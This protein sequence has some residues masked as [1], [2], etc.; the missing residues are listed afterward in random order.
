MSVSLLT[1][2]AAA[3]DSHAAAFAAVRGLDRESA[4]AALSLAANAGDPDAMFALGLLGLRGQVLWEFLGD[5]AAISS[6][7]QAEIWSSVRW[8]RAAADQG[9]APSMARLA[10]LRAL[11]DSERLTWLH[12]AA[13]AGAWRAASRYG[14]WLS[15]AGRK[16]EARRW[17]L[18]DVEAGSANAAEC[19]A[20]FHEEVGEAA[21]AAEFRRLARELHRPPFTGV[22]MAD[23]EPIVITAVATTAVVP[24]VDRHE[25]GL[26]ELVDRSSRA[27]PLAWAAIARINGAEVPCSK[28]VIRPVLAAEYM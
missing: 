8:L 15:Q 6:A 17:Y 23:I 3:G 4:T 22:A 1:R 13:V 27:G 5:E 28:I 26:V 21:A 7:Q 9:H 24:F 20:D 18:V 12:Q 11:S 25:T 19:V 2:A 14:D 10:T 16:D